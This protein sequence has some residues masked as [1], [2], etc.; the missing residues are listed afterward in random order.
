MLRATARAA[1]ELSR[2]SGLNGTTEMRALSL[3]RVRSHFHK[4]PPRPLFLLAFAERQP[5]CPRSSERP[6]ARRTI[7]PRPATAHASTKSSVRPRGYAERIGSHSV[8]EGVCRVPVRSGGPAWT[9]VDDG[10]SLAGNDCADASSIA[11]SRIR[12]ASS[13]SLSGAFLEGREFS[14]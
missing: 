13:S 12:G 3:P 4:R 11:S 5:S 8:A 14:H 10:G 1:F 6:A 9:D 2:T 7:E